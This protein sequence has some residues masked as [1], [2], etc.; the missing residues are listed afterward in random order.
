M[1]RAT[2]LSPARA[3]ILIV[4]DSG[5]NAFVM[6]NNAI[7]LDYGLINKLDPAAMLQGV[8]AH[9]ANGHFARRMTRFTN[10]R[11][12]LG[13]GF[14]LAFAASGYA[15]TAC[16]IAL[17]TTSAAQGALRGHTREEGFPADKSAARY[18]KAGS[19][20]PQELLD[21]L[22]IFAGQETLS[23]GRQDPCVRSHPLG[24]NQLCTV[25]GAVVASG[26]LPAVPTV[27]YWFAHLKD[28]LT[29]YTAAP[30]RTLRRLRAKPH[31]DV[32][33]LRET[34]AQRRNSR[35]KQPLVAID[36]AIASLP[37]NPFPQDQKGQILL[38][39]RN[40]GTAANTHAAAVK[41]GPKDPLL[42]SR[43]GR[44]L[45]ASGQVKTALGVLK[46]SQH[47]EFRDAAMLRDLATGHG[48]S[49]Q[50]GMATFITADY[51]AFQM[52][53]K[54]ARIHAKRA[55]G[56]LSQGSGSWQRAQDVMIASQHT[57]K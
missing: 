6:R 54:D 30:S 31:A 7:L 50:T 49:G 34:V 52:R 19:A 38:E 29:T 42:P 17:G 21:T 15:K 13:L 11:N 28:K 8:I 51:F 26:T 41:R 20:S 36:K 22:T 43:C 2:G 33:L 9:T 40:F 10:A 3:K 14:A 23:V 1:L 39:S 56:L 5:L 35:T 18:T 45:L 12:I 37:K 57:L 53:L 24:P 55:S 4:N 47:Q 27:Q 44:T 25:A 46:K 16:D 32:R 48:K